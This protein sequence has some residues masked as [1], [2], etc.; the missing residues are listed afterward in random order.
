MGYLQMFRLRGIKIPRY[1]AVNNLLY[2]HGINSVAMGI[3]WLK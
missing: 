1:G 3:T 2:S